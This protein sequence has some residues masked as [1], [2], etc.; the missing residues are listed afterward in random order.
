MFSHDCISEE[1]LRIRFEGPALDNHAMDVSVLGPS[2]TGLGELMRESNRTLNGGY[3]GLKVM[4]SADVEANCVTLDFTLLQDLCDNAKQL[5]GMD[6]VKTAK[7]ILEWIGIIAGGTITAGVSVWKLYKWIVDKRMPGQKIT[8]VHHGDVVTI[9]I[10]GSNN[11]ITVSRPVF[12]LASEPSVQEG[13]KEL[14]SPLNQDGIDETAFI[15]KGGEVVITKDEAKPVLE[16]SPADLDVEIDPQI[17]EGHITIHAPT[18]DPK[19]K[20]WKFKWNNRVESV[21]IANSTIAQTILDRGKVVVGDAFKVRME[22]IE[23]RQ[24]S[25]YKQYFK[26]LNVLGFVPNA[27]QQIDLLRRDFKGGPSDDNLDT[28]S[29]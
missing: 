10:E 2:L 19:A 24:K 29:T 26:V 16:A 7:E 3:V 8:P 23:K 28:A 5:L 21:N 9:N 11:Q 1:G 14:L 12:K 18:F 25:G 22:V 4:L 27:E 13:I 15:H 20:N 6:H 17:I